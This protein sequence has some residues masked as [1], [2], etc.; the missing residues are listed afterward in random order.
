MSL[1]EKSKKP[2]KKYLRSPAVAAVVKKNHAI[3]NRPAMK[4]QN[5]NIIQGHNKTTGNILLRL[6]FF[7]SDKTD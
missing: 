2:N 4:N 7:P 1:G 5:G 6:S 3:Q